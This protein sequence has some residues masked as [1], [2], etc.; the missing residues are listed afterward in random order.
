MHLIKQKSRRKRRLL[1]YLLGSKFIVYV[2]EELISKINPEKVD[3]I[4]PRLTS[5]NRNF[6]D[7]Y[8]QKKNTC[9]YNKS[10]KFGTKYIVISIM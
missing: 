8:E 6:Y 10:L 5:Q 2:Y 7:F 4:I 1:V 3:R 9:Y